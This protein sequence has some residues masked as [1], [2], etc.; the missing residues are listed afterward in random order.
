MD[1]PA[2]EFPQSL[3]T[4]G[5]A[6]FEKLSQ[7]CLCASTDIAPR[8]ANGI[9]KCRRCAILFRNPRPTLR[10]II[11]SYN[12]GITYAAWQQEREIRDVLWR[13]RLKV[14]L[15]HKRAGRLLDVGTGDGHFLDF[16]KS[17]FDVDLDGD[18]RNRRATRVTRG[19]RADRRP[20][21]LGLTLT[22][23]HYDVITLWHV[24][25]HLPYPELAVARL[26]RLLKPDGILGD[27]GT[28]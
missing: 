19:T 5:F 22:E 20:A 3:R 6:E 10:Q 8:F 18:Q 23:R 16:L 11:E 4:S 21:L 13:K 25:E 15:R 14:V 2:A 17:S 7:C 9:W 26:R 1:D 12:A 27:R 24:L 28:E